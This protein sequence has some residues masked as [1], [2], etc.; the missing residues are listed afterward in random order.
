MHFVL[1]MLVLLF[2]VNS[3]EF[4]D[5]LLVLG[6]PYL[7]ADVVAVAVLSLVGG[8]LIL[9][10]WCVFMQDALLWGFSVGRLFWHTC[11]LAGVVTLRLWVSW[12]YSVIVCRLLCVGFGDSGFPLVVVW[13]CMLLGLWG[14]MVCCSGLWVGML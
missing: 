5:S 10:V 14:R 13:V 4:M 6:G 3:V 9:R 11:G 1:L 12:L 2:M 8:L 7:E